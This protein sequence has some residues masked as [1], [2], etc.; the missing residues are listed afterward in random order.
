MALLSF[1]SPT[2]CA[3]WPI[4]LLPTCA[5]R[6]ISGSS[7]WVA[8]MPQKLTGKSCKLCVSLG[9]TDELLRSKNWAVSA[10][11]TF[12]SSKR[13]MMNFRGSTRSLPGATPARKICRVLEH[14]AD[15]KIRA[16]K[17]SKRNS[18]MWTNSAINCRHTKIKVVSHR[19]KEFN[20]W[21]EWSLTDHN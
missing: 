20:V 5:F 16:S 13:S 11:E 17:H 7:V 9:Q 1:A 6:A 10:T 8:Q 18:L 14:L 2:P 4:A 3:M 19:R 15:S 12:R 21:E